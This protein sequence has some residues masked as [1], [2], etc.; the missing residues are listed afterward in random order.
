M[1]TTGTYII[2]CLICLASGALMGWGITVVNW[3][4]RQTDFEIMYYG[5]MRELKALWE[6][7]YPELT[8]D[9]QERGR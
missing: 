4:I 5:A 9:F 6:K 1:I 2:G 8:R 7:H 3:R